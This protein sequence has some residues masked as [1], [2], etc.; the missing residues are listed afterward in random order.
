MP[1]R[2]LLRK[3]D[4]RLE[5]HNL[6]NEDDVLIIAD[7]FG[8]SFSA[9]YYRIRN[10]FDYSL[11]FLENDKKKFK[12]DHRRQELGMSY[13]PLYESLFD[14]WT[15]IKNSVETEYAKHI[16]KANYVYNDSRLEGVATT[17]EMCIRDR[18]D[19]VRASEIS[20]LGCSIYAHNAKGKV[21]RAYEKLVQEVI[22]HGI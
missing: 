1:K 6:L 14:A 18:T 13:L 9:C 17:K 12:P 21:A 11:G 19:S 8:V 22:G 20:A 16:F 3:I 7:H 2:E 4:E 10:L 5:E 15:W